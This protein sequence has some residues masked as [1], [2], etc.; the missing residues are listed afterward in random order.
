MKPFKVVICGGGVAGIEGLLR[1]RKL[2]GDRVDITLLSAKEEFAYRPIAV[3]EPFA[4][5]QADRYPIARIAADTGARWI[6]D[7]LA[8]VDRDHRQVHTSSHDVVDY[9][10]LLLAVGGRERKRSEHMEVFS[11]RNAD[12]MHRA[13]LSDIEAGRIKSLAFV[14]PSGPSWALPLY[15]LALLTADQVRDKVRLDIAFITPEPLPMQVFGQDPRLSPRFCAM[16]GSGCTASRTY[17][18]SEHGSCTCTPAAPICVRTG[19]SRS[20]Q[21]PDRTSPG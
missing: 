20:R 18:S 15:E 10:A 4:K 11:D 9:D 16:R 17:V 21:S 12:D 8:W 3:L 14:M 1:L 13:I 19:S 6:R 5:G 2:A 7:S